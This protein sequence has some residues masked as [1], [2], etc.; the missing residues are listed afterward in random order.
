MVNLLSD[1]HLYLRVRTWFIHLIDYSDM[2]EKKGAN[3]L[4]KLLDNIKPPS[5]TWN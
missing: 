4:D 2:Y 1:R 3:S 5:T